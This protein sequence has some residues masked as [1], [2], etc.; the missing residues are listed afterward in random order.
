MGVVKVKKGNEVFEIQD[1]DLKDAVKDGYLPTDT[2]IVANSKTKEMFEIAPEDLPDAFSDGFDFSGVKKKVGGIGSALGGA[3]GTSVPQSEEDRIASLLKTVGRSA[4]QS[5][6]PQEAQPEFDRNDPVRS[7]YAPVRNKLATLRQRPVAES[8]AQDPL[9]KQ[10][11]SK[12][13]SDALNAKAALDRQRVFQN[14]GQAVNFLQQKLDNSKL[15]PS[16]P[17]DIMQR[18]TLDDF[19]E[20]SILDA[21]KGNETLELATKKYLENKKVKESIYSSNSLDEAAIKL[22]ALKGDLTSK[23]I[24]ALNGNIP[25]SMQANLLIGLLNDENTQELAEN[26][27]ELKSKILETAY[28]LPDKYPQAA[29]TYLA[30]VLSQERENR[31][32]NNAV[33]NFSSIGT[34]DYIVKDLVEKGKLPVQY[35]NLYNNPAI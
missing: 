24:Q 25:K 20:E 6:L 32:L 19:T 3:V 12:E 29:A 18:P 31:G 2:V 17:I 13:I 34:N 11:R 22:A 33:L 10:Q 23:Q 4:D 35:Q 1:T 30:Q 14:T 28:N 5:P 16:K 8:V 9:Q 26:D 7:I 15:V 27:A 21:A